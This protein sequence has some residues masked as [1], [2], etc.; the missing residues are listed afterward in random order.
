MIE[1]HDPLFSA[2]AWSCSGSVRWI[3]IFLR[4]FKGAL[5]SCMEK[6]RN[7]NGSWQH[8]TSKIRPELTFPLTHTMPL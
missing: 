6:V 1:D 7:Q 5:S 8:K 2:V 3:I 4:G